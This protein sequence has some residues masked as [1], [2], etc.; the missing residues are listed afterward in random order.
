[1]IIKFVIGRGKEFKS[2]C[3]KIPLKYT[4]VRDWRTQFG[5]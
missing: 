1:M 4:A 2:F 3:I 5:R